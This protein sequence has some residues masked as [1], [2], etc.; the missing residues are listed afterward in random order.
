MMKRDI[1]KV[2]LAI[3]LML[4]AYVAPAPRWLSFFAFSWA[5]GSRFMDHLS[6]GLGEALSETVMSIFCLLMP[7]QTADANISRS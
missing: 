2:C 1:R 4:P 7:G 3:L 6:T 5:R